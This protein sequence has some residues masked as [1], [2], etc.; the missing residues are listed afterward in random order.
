MQNQ[1]FNLPK[2]CTLYHMNSWL[3]SKRNTQ[4]F[5]SCSINYSAAT[6]EPSAAPLRFPPFDNDILKVYL[7]FSSNS[8]RTFCLFIM[9]QRTFQ[10]AACASCASTPTGT[11]P[12]HVHPTCSA[13]WSA[14]GC[15]PLPPP[16]ACCVCSL[17]FADF[18]TERKGGQA[19]A[20]K[21]EAE[22][23]YYKEREC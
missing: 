1:S 14:L 11:Q 13:S 20:G 21:R 5:V 12:R 22:R 10:S 9:C 17:A 18:Y 8:A 19:G 3:I 4:Q 16:P 15:R 7:I 6:Q 2:R 23:E